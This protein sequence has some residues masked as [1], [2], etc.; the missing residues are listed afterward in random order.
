MSDKYRQH[1][2]IIYEVGVGTMAI[3]CVPTTG[4]DTR[5]VGIADDGW[6]L[7]MKNGGTILAALNAQQAAPA[8]EFKANAKAL[9]RLVLE[10]FD[11]KLSM[12]LN[13]QQNEIRRLAAL[14]AGKGE[15]A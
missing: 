8:P 1:G 6:E 7:A 5:P 9:A 2:N 14:V 11:G 3:L 13:D 15:G 12:P 4:T 10:F